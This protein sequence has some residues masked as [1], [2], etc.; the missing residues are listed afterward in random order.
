M[1]QLQR[2]VKSFNTQEVL[3]DVSMTFESERNHV[4]VGPSGVGKS[5]LL[6]IVSGQMKPDKGK[7]LI[8]G[9]PKLGT[10]SMDYKQ[11]IGFVYQSFN[12]LENLTVEENVKLP[13]V[14]QGKVMDTDYIDQLL[15][16]ASIIDQR[17]KYPNQLSGGQQ[18]RVGIVRAL[19]NQPKY[20]LCDEPTSALDNETSLKLIDTLSQIIEKHKTTLIMVTH[21]LSLAKTIATDIH[22][23]SSNGSVQHLLP[24]RL[25]VNG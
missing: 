5:T 4:I 6:K 21:D 17:H 8:N 13:L 16:E 2:V 3:K 24:N 1:I 20:L 14:I 19:I 9:D 23:F 7:I 11:Q 22:Q 18:Q 10:H 25:V 15:L 12:L